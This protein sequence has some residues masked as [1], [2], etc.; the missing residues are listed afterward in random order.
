M[1]QLHYTVKRKIAPDGAIFLTLESE[2][3][4]ECLVGRVIFFLEIV[5]VLSSVGYH[6][7]Q[8]AS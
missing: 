6:L 7:E 4:D 2:L 8:T 3:L 5:Q 1:L